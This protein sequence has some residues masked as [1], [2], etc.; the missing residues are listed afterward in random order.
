MLRPPSTD[1]A[2]NAYL[3]FIENKLK[4]FECSPKVKAYLTLYYQLNDL[5]DQLTIGQAEKKT[6][7]AGNEFT[8]VP[9]R[10]DLF[11]LGSEKEFDRGA[12]VFDKIEPWMTMLD[13][14][15]ASMNPNEKKEIEGKIVKAE[16]VEEF[17]K[18]NGKDAKSKVL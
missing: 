18:T 16:G 13:R 6:D 2:I 8:V 15:R 7:S 4:V 17:L 12:K 11:G 5:L 9:G 3:D 1:K 14:I 10:M